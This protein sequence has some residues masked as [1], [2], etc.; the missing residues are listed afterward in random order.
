MLESRRQYQLGII[1]MLCSVTAWSTAGLF[2]RFLTVDTFTV[3]FWRSV[4]GALGLLVVVAFSREG[5]GGM[6]RIGKPG[7]IYAAVTALSMFFYIGGVMN[8]T[9]AHAAV[10]TATV[11]FIAAYMAWIYLKEVPRLFSIIASAVALL[12][13][14]LMMG[15][16]TEGR[17]LGDALTFGMAILVGVMIMITRKFT[18]IPPMPVTLLSAVLC[19]LSALPMA[20]LSISW[21]QMGVL[22]LFGLTNQVIGFGFFAMASRILP[23]LETGLIT[24]LDAP[25]QP[26]WVFLVFAETP[27]QATLLG[28]G[29]VLVSVFANILMQNRRMARAALLGPAV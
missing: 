24:A 17:L 9:I 25:L 22:A 11:P 15:I 7:F 28:G 6:K 20:Q 10:M 2:T 8:T 18:S 12:G 21:E 4:F 5:L 23:P 16:S 3:I 26:L 19:T 13:V 14:A 1:L 27:G 29:L